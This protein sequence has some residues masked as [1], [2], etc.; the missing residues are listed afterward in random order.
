M[1]FQAAHLNRVRR[2][3]SVL[4]MY[5]AVVACFMG[6]PAFGQTGNALSLS[7]VDER[8]SALRESGTAKDSSI[9]KNYSDARD[10]LVQ[11]EVLQLERQQS[12]EAL[13]VA[14]V[15]E[16]E[17]QAR[18]DRLESSPPMEGDLTSLDRNELNAQLLT[19]SSDEEEAGSLITLVNSL[20]RNRCL[21]AVRCLYYINIESSVYPAYT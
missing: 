7:M 5:L 9:Y 2:V 10:M 4:W 18:I 13:R 3:H 16:S 15:R 14:P 12:V 8:L 19:L 21:S 6:Q 20:G 1:I 11:A 17:T